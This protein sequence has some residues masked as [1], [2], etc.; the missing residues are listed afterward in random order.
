MK[1]NFLYLIFFSLYLFVV[2][3]LSEARLQQPNYVYDGKNLQLMGDSP[4]QGSYSQWQIWLYPERVHIPHHTAGLPYSRWGLIE[5]TSAETVIEQLETL[6]GFER[7]YL[8]FFGPDAWG[9]DTFFNALGPIAVTMQAVK[10][11]PA[12]AFSLRLLNRRMNSLIAAIQPSLE[13]NKN[14]GMTSSVKDYFDQARDGFVQVGKLSS[15]L[16]HLNPNLHFI[17]DE[18]VRTLTA[19]TRAENKVREITA[20]LPSVRL[21]TSNAW[22]FHTEW[23]GSDGII[24]VAVTEAGSG[25]SVE[26]TWTGGDGSMTGLAV[27]TTVPYKDIGRVELKAPTRNGD[28]AWTVRVQSA[29]ASFAETWSAPERKTRSRVLPAV[30]L[31]TTQNIVYLSFDNPAGAQDAYAYFLYH[32]ELGR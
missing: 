7:A 23:A 21:P 32:Q 4:A 13:N 16:S 3:P 30:N 14:E 5:G 11:A 29:D 31:R 18:M 22:M 6:Q 20:V 1:R 25:V 17:N 12:E 10:N 9:H 15:Q 2:A 24:Q 8:N 19:V 28:K 27:L 26:R